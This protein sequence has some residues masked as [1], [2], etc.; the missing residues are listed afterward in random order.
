[1]P[2]A[3]PKPPPNIM[4]NRPAPS[5][6]PIIPDRNGWREKKP[7]CAAGAAW[8]TLVAGLALCVGVA[9][10]SIGAALGAVLVGA[11]A[12][13]VLEP[14]LPLL[15]PPPTRAWAMTGTIKITAAIAASQRDLFM[16][17]ATLSLD[18]AN[19]DNVRWISRHFKVPYRA[20]KR[21]KLQQ[22]HSKARPPSLP[23]A[24]P[25]SARPARRPWPAKA[26]KS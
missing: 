2:A 9:L 7:P 14:R 4:P 21:G 22:C 18:I 15:V 6:P 8:A 10:R 16:I 5:M 26:P 23:A 24:H 11:G 1:M 13:P 3:P 12:A 17:S 19:A 20:Q 25:A